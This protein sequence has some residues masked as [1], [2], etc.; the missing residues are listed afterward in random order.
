MSR[1]LTASRQLGRRPLPRARCTGAAQGLRAGRSAGRSAGRPGV[2][3]GLAHW[4]PDA[5][6][7]GCASFLRMTFYTLT[8][9]WGVIG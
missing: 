7:S 8:W 3:A 2:S 6:K 9:T 4:L 1:S 5:R